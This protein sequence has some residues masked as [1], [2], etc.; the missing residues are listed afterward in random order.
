MK[1]NSKKILGYKKERVVLADILPYEVPPFFSNRFFYH[2]LIDN[3]IQISEDQLRFKKEA[4]K[5]LSYLISIL[6]GFDRTN[7]ITSQLDYDYYTIN[8]K[9]LL[10]IPFKFKITHKDSDFRE[11]SVI[12]PINQLSLVNFYDKYKYIIIKNCELSPF[13]LRRPSKISSLKYFK[14]KTNKSKLANTPELEVIESSDKEY[15]SLKTFFSYSKFSNIHKFYESYD[16]Q[17]TEMKFDNLLKFDISRCFDSIYTHTLPWALSNKKIVKENLDSTKLSFGGNF[18]V[19]M[20]KMNYNE[21][22]GIVIGPEFSRIFA[23]LILQR[24]DENVR[25]SLISKNYIYKKD[26]DIFRYVDDYFLFF[27]NEDVKNDILSIY[28]VK[29]KEYN[30][31]FNDAKTVLQTKPIITNITIAKEE[32]RKLVEQSMIFRFSDNELP[33]QIGVKYY[34][35]KDIITNYK[36]ILAN[37]NT[38]YKDLQNYF[39]AII[40][41]KLKNLVLEIGKEEKIFLNLVVEKIA[42]KKEIDLLNGIVPPELSSRFDEILVEVSEKGKLLENLN[43]E[44][45]KNIKEIIELTFFIYSVL[46]RVTYSIKVCHILFRIIDFIKNQEKTKQKFTSKYHVE[47]ENELKSIGF[48]FDKKHILFKQIFNGISLVFG[49]NTSN[50]FAEVETLYLL[51]IINELGTHYSLPEKTLIEHFRVFKLVGKKEVINELNYFT[52]ISILNHIKRDIKYSSLR[53]HLLEIILKKLSKFDKKY[54][55]D[56]FLL[57]DLLSCPYTGT[58]DDEVK[59]FKK[60]ILEA[61]KFYRSNIP[62]NDKLAFVDKFTNFGASGFFKWENGD[63]GKELNT[64]RGHDV[65]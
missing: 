61:I 28:K 34:N 31:F 60:K 14:D 46:P 5:T 16:F 43:S 4:S 57:V 45:Y 8:E 24:I 48:D 63:F 30:L 49:K 35:A 27:T 55:E 32:I 64:K 9:S 52:I 18:D 25:K 65:Y 44:V 53:N 37:T 50:E 26:Y 59:Q 54:A 58:T 10:T 1:R 42:L 22:N 38:S 51:P 12:H 47:L 62:N 13:S 17:K 29:L 20:Q 56:V 39:L 21:T 41:N 6:F 36:A 40:Y 33:N 11:L 15:T 7:C 3:K 23:E 19:V 2:F